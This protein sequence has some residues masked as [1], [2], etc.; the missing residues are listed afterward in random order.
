MFDWIADTFT[1]AQDVLFQ[2]V[3]MPIT[4]AVGLGGYV[5]DAYPGTEWLL[6]GLVQIAVL[7][8]IFRPLERWRPVEP[9]QDR[10]AVRADIFYT[11][12]HRLGFFPLLMFFTLQP[13]IDDLDGKL[14]FWGW[15]H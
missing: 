11:L 7:L 8:L 9:L 10:K 1:Q 4:Y 5:E 15:A 3:V 13:L 6:M 12:F 2:H 14:R